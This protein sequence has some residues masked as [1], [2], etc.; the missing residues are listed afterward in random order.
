MI[1]SS[2]E[3]I[4]VPVANKEDAKETA[5]AMR[6]YLIGNNTT[7]LVIHVVQIAGGYMNKS[8]LSAQKNVAND[9]LEVASE[10]F[11]DE[12]IAVETEIR[13]GKDVIEEIFQAA[14]EFNADYIGFTPRRGGRLSRLLSGDLSNK[15]VSESRWPIAVFPHSENR[16]NC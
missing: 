12:G 4:V 9:A 13:Y 15:L 1:T 10:K 3:R 16:E 7:I 14:T 8:P 11:F 5:E 2:A 6:P